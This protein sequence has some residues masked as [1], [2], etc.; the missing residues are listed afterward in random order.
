MDIEW[1][2]NNCNRTYKTRLGAYN[3][4][5]KNECK[6]TRDEILTRIA[7]AMERIAEAYEHITKEDN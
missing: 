4:C 3:C 1:T 5:N 7:V 2:C 6:E